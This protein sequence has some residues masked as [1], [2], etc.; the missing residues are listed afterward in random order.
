M[1]INTLS[2]FRRAM[3]HGPYAWP[4]GYPA[5]FVMSDGGA[6]SFAAARSER[7]QI[8]AALADY[9]NGNRRERS[10]WR[11]V[12]LEINWEDSELACAHTGKPIE[13]AYTED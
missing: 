2:D 4:G 8:I 7:R 6:L 10:G 1:P 5:Y 11:P 3:R 13:A 12:A 9:Q